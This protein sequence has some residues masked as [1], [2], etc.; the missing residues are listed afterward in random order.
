[1]FLKL[2]PD[3]QDSL[4]QKL[5]DDDPILRNIEKQFMK[6]HGT[7]GRIESVQANSGWE[8]FLIV[9]VNR[10]KGKTRIPSIYLGTIVRKYYTS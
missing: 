6:E 7:T 1:M 9:R 4:I 2:N 3:E 8:N 10:K 5:D